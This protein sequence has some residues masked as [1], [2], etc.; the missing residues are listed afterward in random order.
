MYAA[1]GLLPLSSWS[2]GIALWRAGNWE[3][4]AAKLG[5]PPPPKK[6]ILHSQLVRRRLNDTG[7]ESRI[8][9]KLCYV[10]KG[11]KDHVLLK[12]AVLFQASMGRPCVLTAY[13][14]LCCES[15]W[16]FWTMCCWSLLGCSKERLL[17]M[18]VVPLCC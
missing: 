12:Y 18:H 7:R 13:Q 14:L 10:L 16:S 3:A 2:E 8:V 11:P 4:A 15:F 5:K 1:V 6:K 17:A 9:V